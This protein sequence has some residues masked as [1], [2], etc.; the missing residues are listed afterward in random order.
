M[1][2]KSFEKCY[3]GKHLKAYKLTYENKV[4]K[5]KVYEMVSRNDLNT[6]YEVA[7]KVNGIAIVGFYKGKML[8]LKEFRMAVNSFI[9]NLCAGKI[10][11]GET[12]EECANR[13]L[14]EETGLKIKKII[15][16]LEPCYSAVAISDIKT[17]LVFVSLYGEISDHTSENEE[18]IAGLYS[19]EEVAHMLKTEK[20]S[21]RGQLAAYCFSKGFFDSYCDLG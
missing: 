18:I 9:Y 7:S 12:Y 2:L 10:E 15:D 14:Y 11:D 4:G 3:D 6:A 21:S 1:K 5:D 16:V 19:K 20:F 17:R 8:L 13:E